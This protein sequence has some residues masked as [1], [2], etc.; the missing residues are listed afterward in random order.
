MATD[1]GVPVTRG[2]GVNLL[3]Q[4]LIPHRKVTG[5]PKSVAI[6]SNPLGTWMYQIVS[7]LNINCEE[8]T[9]VLSVPNIVLVQRIEA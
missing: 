4:N 8:L 7:H 9:E 3:Q 2:P 5:T 1:S 6:F